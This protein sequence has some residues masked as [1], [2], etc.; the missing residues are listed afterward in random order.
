[1]TQRKKTQ[2]EADETLV[3]IVEVRDQAQSFIDRNQNLVFGILIGLVVIVGGI[4]AYRNFLLKPRQQEAV[5]QMYQAQNQ[6][7]RDSFALALTNPGGGFL[8][9][10]DVIDKYKGTKAANLA[11]YYAGISYL[12]LGQY[13]AAVDYLKDFN[14]KGDI[15]PM[16]KFGALG[17]AYSELND[18]DKALQFYKR[19]V[20]AGDN[21]AIV[22][23]Y[24]KKLG[25]LY[26][27]QNDFAKAKEAYQKIKDEYSN[28][29][30]GQDI[31]KYLIRVSRQG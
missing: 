14:P 3:D 7:D 23:Y 11:L 9:F 22:P 18:F 16:M 8:G 25:M 29:V 27:R 5:E 26:E 12:N 4:F 6:F 28:T 24:L 1:M 31:D 17:D 15:T 30:Y 2:K 21:D 13:E 20:D 10:L 19:A